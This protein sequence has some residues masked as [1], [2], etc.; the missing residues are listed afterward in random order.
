MTMRE[1]VRALG[2][3][4]TL[5]QIEGSVAL[6]APLLPP[7]DE[8]AVVRDLAYGA[9]PRHRLDLFGRAPGAARPVVAFIHG[10]GFIRGDKGGP[11]TPFYSNVGG[12]AA[13]QGWIG[14]TASYRLAPD[15]PWPAG[16]EDVA[17]L[18]AWLRANVATHGGDPARIVLIG[19]SAGAAHVASYVGC[20]PFADDAARDVAGAVLMSGLYDLAGQPHSP[21]ETA[22]YGSDPSRFTAQSSVA[23]LARTALPCLFTLSEWDPGEFHR[24]AAAAVQGWVEAKG[25]WP[26]F[27][28]LEGQ[29]HITPVHQIGG[30]ADAVGPVLARFVERVTATGQAD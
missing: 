30:A 12:W 14:V 20:A 7:V 3:E 19:Q 18:V 13:R 1:R 11:D 28:L 15:H 4:F 29:N 8:R 17:A 27:A 26:D 2:M 25:R 22:Y 23:G 5:A 9:H 21:F 16:G 24:H 6:F 10:G